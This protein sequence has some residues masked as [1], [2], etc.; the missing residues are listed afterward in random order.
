M[1]DSACCGSGTFRADGC[2]SSATVCEN[3]DNYLFWD[4]Y[5]PSNAATKVAANDVFGDPGIYVHPV[6]VQ[7]LVQPRPRAQRTVVYY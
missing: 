3:R 6:N 5:H 4:D 2:D 1:L 7:Q